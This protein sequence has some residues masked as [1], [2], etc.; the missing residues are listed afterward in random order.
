VLADLVPPRFPLSALK[1]LLDY[2]MSKNLD[3]TWA[4]NRIIWSHP[5]VALYLGASKSDV[6]KAK[7]KQL[8]KM[9]KNP[10]SYDKVEEVKDYLQSLGLTLSSQFKGKTIADRYIR[11][12][13]GRRV[14]EGLSGTQLTGLGLCDQDTLDCALLHAVH[15]G[16]ADITKSLLE[17]GAN[18]NAITMDG[19]DALRYAQELGHTDIAEMLQEY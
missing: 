16:D 10:K 8:F 17:D 1:P 3:R 6:R 7:E 4:I 9:L 12:R 2:L 5:E 15:I 18:P 11:S 19:R 14:L 13:P